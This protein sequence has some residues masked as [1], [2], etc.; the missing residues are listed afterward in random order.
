MFSLARLDL[1]KFKENLDHINEL[2]EAVRNAVK[3][4][5]DQ[6]HEEMEAEILKKEN[7]R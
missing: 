3:K 1:E 2:S 4:R 5:A 6:L 7:R